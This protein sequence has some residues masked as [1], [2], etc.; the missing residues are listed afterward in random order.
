[1]WLI[2][3]QRV[4]ERLNALIRFVLKHFK[5]KLQNRRTPQVTAMELLICE[6]IL[7]IL[8]LATGSY[9]F[10]RYENWQYFDAFYYCLSTL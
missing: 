1:M 10:Y 7:I 9:V 6:L 2:M 8:T 4:G 3:I 5:R